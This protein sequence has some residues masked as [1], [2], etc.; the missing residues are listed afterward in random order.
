MTPY[1]N[2][3]IITERRT[4][5]GRCCAQESGVCDFLH[6]LS[7]A[8]HKGGVDEGHNNVCVKF[9]CEI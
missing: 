5:K 6:G 4:R 9:L 8:Q 7:N 2:Q 1:L 3:G